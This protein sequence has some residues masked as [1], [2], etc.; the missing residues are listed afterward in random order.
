M[1]D[2]SLDSGSGDFRR[3]AHRGNLPKSWDT[4]ARRGGGVA[5]LSQ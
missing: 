5:A 1:S 3:C 4:N 2:P